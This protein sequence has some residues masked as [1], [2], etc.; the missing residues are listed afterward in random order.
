MFRKLLSLL[1]TSNM[2][3]VAGVSEA[4]AKTNDTH[5][6]SA[7]VRAE[8]RRLGPGRL[9]P[10]G[11]ARVELNDKT[12]NDKTRLSGTIVG[13]GEDQFVLRDSLFSATRKTSQ[14]V[15]VPYASVRKLRGI[16]PSGSKILLLGAAQA[17]TALIVLA[18]LLGVVVALVASDKS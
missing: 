18:V 9:G 8:A 13:I 11:A 15:P 7:K 6:H 2:L 17:K 16:A 3:V 14:N 10:G 1:L 4:G 5:A 12:T